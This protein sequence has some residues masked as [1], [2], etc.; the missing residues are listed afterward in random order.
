MSILDEIEV[1]KSI[2]CQQGEFEAIDLESSLS[3][4][5]KLNLTHAEENCQQLRITFYISHKYPEVVPH[6]TIDSPMLT[7]ESSSG[8]N[9]E[10]SKFATENNLLNSQMLLD[11]ILWIKDNVAKFASGVN[12][13]R[14]QGCG[15]EGSLT[16]NKT[17]EICVIQLDH[18]RSKNN[19]LKTLQKWATQLQVQGV[20]LFYK[21]LIFII[22]YG[23]KND[24][25]E[26]LKKMRTQKVDIDSAG[27]ACF[28]KRFL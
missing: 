6:V 18:M 26:Y 14:L 21:H 3:K 10:M 13:N 2:Y 20:V 7:R 17:K 23:N 16:K 24:I 5:F 1:V 4:S 19:Y 9:S 15:D 22:L 12:S 28:I 11:L 8:L 27:H 25:K